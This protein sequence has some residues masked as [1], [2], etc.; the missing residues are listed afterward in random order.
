ML[1]F[2]RRVKAEL[3]ADLAQLRKDGAVFALTTDQW[4]WG[5][6]RFLGEYAE[7][8]N[9]HTIIPKKIIPIAARALTHVP[10]YRRHPTFYEGNSIVLL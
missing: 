5:R 8:F 10:S 6:K 9:Y 2:C 4:T 3:A 1:V 7:S